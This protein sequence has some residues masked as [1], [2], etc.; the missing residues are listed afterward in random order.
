MNANWQLYIQDLDG[1]QSHA[2]PMPEGYQYVS[3]PNWQADGKG[4]YFVAGK[5]KALDL[6]HYD[7]QSN[8][9]SQL[10][11]GQEAVAHPMAMNN[12]ELLYLSITAEGPNIKHFAEQP[13][14][15]EVVEL[16]KA[17]LRRE[18]M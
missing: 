12:G 9:L 8:S 17:Q 15:L 3:Q 2:V 13:H 11:Q 7:L 1:Q 16:A 4:L 5:N 6:Y 18:E 10:T 14:G